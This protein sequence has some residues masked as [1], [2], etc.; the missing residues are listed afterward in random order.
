M[1]SEYF[2]TSSG[3]CEEGAGL[4]YIEELPRDAFYASGYEGQATLVIP[5]KEVS[6]LY[7]PST[8]LRVLS[9]CGCS[10]LSYA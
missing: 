3:E 2:C 10:W 9:E 8:L 1:L 6:V 4:R 5:S 7:L